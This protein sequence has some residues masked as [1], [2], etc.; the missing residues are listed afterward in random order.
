MQPII[1]D[2]VFIKEA[3]NN[4]E[5]RHDALRMYLQKMDGVVLDEM[6]HAINEVVTPLVDCTTCGGCCRQLMIN[7]TDKEHE[8]VAAHLQM[9]AVAFKQQY[10]EESLQGKL[11]MS[12]IP[13]HFLEASKCTIYEQRFNE[14]RA[15]PHLHEPNF[16]GRLFGTLVHYAMCPIIYNV[17][18]ELQYASGFMNRPNITA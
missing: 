8:T 12:T 17:I 13:C 14:C 11:I 9:S 3:A 15:F 2:R 16:K 1:T 10:L 7:V 4:N 18:E 6:V 5:D